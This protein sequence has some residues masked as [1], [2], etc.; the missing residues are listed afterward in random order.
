MFW[1]KP[2]VDREHHHIFSIELIGPLPCVTRV[3]EAIVGYEGSTMEMDDHLLYFE[4]QILFGSTHAFVY[5][6]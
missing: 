5:I 2:I 3:L 4:A 1:G 6:N